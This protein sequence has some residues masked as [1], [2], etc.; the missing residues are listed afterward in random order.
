MGS[1]EKERVDSLK[2]VSL[3]R[4]WVMLGF[5]LFNINLRQD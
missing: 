3:R 2:K 1:R 4:T 5:K